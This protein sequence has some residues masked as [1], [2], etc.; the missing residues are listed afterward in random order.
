MKKNHR[1]IFYNYIIIINNKLETQQHLNPKS[2]L[3]RNF[4]RCRMDFGR[5]EHDDEMEY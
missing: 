1:L 5:D 4:Y 2:K 3:Q